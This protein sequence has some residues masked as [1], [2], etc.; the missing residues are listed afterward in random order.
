[1][2]TGT[3]A[4]ARQICLFE[5]HSK[6]SNN[7]STGT[8]ATLICLRSGQIKNYSLLVERINYL[9]HFIRSGRLAITKTTTKDIYK[10]QDPAKNTGVQSLLKLCNVF[11]RFGPNLPRP[12][13][14]LNRKLRTDQQIFILKLTVQE[15]QTV[16]YLKKT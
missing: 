12:E 7:P 1:M 4:L 6:S 11:R 9:G 14:P 13:V 3:R 10:L 15:K 5:N 16:D 8:K 2:A